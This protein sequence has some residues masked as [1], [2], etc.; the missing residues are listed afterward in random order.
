MDAIG[1]GA[2]N[3]DRLYSVRKLA[4]RG[5]HEPIRQVCESPGGSAAN[6]IVGLSRL[7]FKTGFIGAVGCDSEGE[8]ILREF[9]RD[10]VC[11]EHVKVVD[12]RTGI[13]IGFVES[14]GE[15]TMY[16]YPGANNTLVLSARDIKFAG[17]ARVVHM[18]SFVGG[19]QLKEQEKLI[20]K[21]SGV[22]ISFSPGHLYSSKGLSK[23]KTIVERTCILFLNED[24]LSNLTGMSISGGTKK[25]LD[26]GV[27]CAAVTL[28]AEGCFVRTQDES[29]LVKAK[30]IKAVDTTG[31]GDAF[32][33][34][35]LAGYMKN[36]SVRECGILGNTVA[37]YCIKG[38]GAR[39]LPKRKEIKIKE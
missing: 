35:F 37:G 38:F 29:V 4:K 8:T 23:L 1:I 31:A 16:P 18:S 34:G 30:R 17:K 27:Q 7:G 19:K 22:K 5:T 12:D 25:L 13:I 33:A 20:K 9:K 39:Y 11:V 36:K 2:L 14:K 3:Y 28:G 21:L 15:R 10:G 24:E 6:T 32:A 26:A